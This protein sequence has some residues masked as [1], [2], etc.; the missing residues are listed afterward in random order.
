V[1][2]REAEISE[3][4]ETVLGWA[5]AIRRLR[6]RANAD[7][8]ADAARAA[9]SAPKGSASAGTEHMFMRASANR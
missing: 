6:V 1:P 4:L 2:L 9:S 7:T 5:D 3:D 8:P